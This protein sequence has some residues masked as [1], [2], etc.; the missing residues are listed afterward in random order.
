MPK[1]DTT[2]RVLSTEE[3]RQFLNELFGE[4]VHAMRV[5]SLANALTG[6]LH[7]AALSVHAIGQGLAQ[8]HNLTP[9]H[10]VKQIDRLL[11]NAGIDLSELL[12]EWVA[13]VVQGR[14]DI[15]VT[16]DWTDFD[17]DNH[18]TLVLSLV[19]SHGRAT[20]LVWKTVVKSELKDHR[21]EHE[22]ELLEFFE[23][24]L[25]GPVKVTLLADRGFGDQKLYALLAQLGF[26]FVIRFR[27][28]I[29]V[30]APDGASAPAAQ[31]V[32]ANGRPK[33]IRDARVT[34]DRALVAGVVCVKAKAMKDAWCLATS[35]R[36]LSAAEVVKL[37]GRR[38][39]TEETFRDGKDPR[40][41]LGLSQTKIGRPDRRDRLLLLSALAQ[42]LLTLL[43]AAS[44]ETGLDRMLKVN[45][46]KKR[47]HSLFRQGLYWYGAIP[48]MDEERLSLLMHAFGRIVLQ[49]TFF[50]RLFGVL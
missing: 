27:G 20:P 47:T 12:P 34:Q 28:N 40:Y 7:A 17:K 5:L 21:N 3:I 18:S 23:R 22:D 33:L 1:A 48:N 6:V 19:T 37:Y 26:D 15:V 2:K 9:K 43:G 39:T 50:S 44:E 49:H 35:R 36:D 13:F 38:F 42:A 46:A 25:P 45:T 14:E 41:G 29:H 24:C 10:A 8:A 4:D 16:L 32:P 11:S 30:E 31:W